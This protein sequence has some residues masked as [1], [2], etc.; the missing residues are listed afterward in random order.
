MYH[1]ILV[2]CESFW[3]QFFY[4]SNLQWY[5]YY[6]YFSD[7]DCCTRQC[8]GPGRPFEMKVFDNMQREV[9]HLS[10]PLRCQCCCCPCCLQ[11]M[12]IQSPP[13]TIIGYVEQKLVNNMKMRLTWC[14]GLVQATAR[15]FCC[16]LIGKTLNSLLSRVIFGND[17]VAEIKNS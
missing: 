13:G 10:R 6:N 3:L 4:L 16:V 11:E 8:C 17:I 12:E 1:I 5:T 7:T 14:G 2:W 9:M 15:S